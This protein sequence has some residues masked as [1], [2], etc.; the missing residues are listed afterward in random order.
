MENGTKFVQKKDLLKSEMNEEGPKKRN[1]PNLSIILEDDSEK[2][3][4]GKDYL[5]EDCSNLELMEVY[6]LEPFRVVQRD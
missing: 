1:K 5:T 3:E 6:K 2:D 4:G